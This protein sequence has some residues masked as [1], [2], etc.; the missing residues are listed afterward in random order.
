MGYYSD[1]SDGEGDMLSTC[2][3]ES[4]ARRLGYL[5]VQHGYREG[6]LAFSRPDEN[7]Y[8]QLVRVWYRTGTV[9]TY[10][11]HP[12]RGKD[13]LFRRNV[14]RDYGLLERIFENPRAHTGKGYYRKRI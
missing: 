13:A 12:T 7:G 4:I 6:V 2:E 10:L 5:K 3:I 14:G 8:K 11:K 1:D 9:G